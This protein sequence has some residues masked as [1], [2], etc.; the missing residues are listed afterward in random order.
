MIFEINPSKEMLSMGEPKSWMLELIQWLKSVNNKI[1]CV[2]D[3][4]VD[5]I[6]EGYITEFTVNTTKSY[7]VVER[8]LFKGIQDRYL[9]SLKLCIKILLCEKRVSRMNSVE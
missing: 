8:E 3:Y 2:V 5:S 7:N 1:S 4:W 6:L 9:K